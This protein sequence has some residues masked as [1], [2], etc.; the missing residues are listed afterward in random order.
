MIEDRIKVCWNETKY[1][2]TVLDDNYYP[3]DDDVRFCNKHLKKTIIKK[4][5]YIV[6][7]TTSIFGITK[8]IIDSGDNK[9]VKVNINKLT[10]IHKS[11]KD[12]R[13]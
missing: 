6:D 9:I 10:V 12:G 11:K 4:Y 3:T 8:A 13:K 7:Y 5:G 2:P 1:V